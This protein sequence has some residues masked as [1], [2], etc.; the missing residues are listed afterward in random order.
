MTN[1]KNF[2]KLWQA[3]LVF[4]KRDL[5][6]RYA[7]SVLGPAWIVLYPLALI[8][9]TT[10]VFSFVF[11]QELELK[12][13][14]LHVMIGFIHWLFFSQSILK[15][16][17]AFPG[18]SGLI[19][20]HQFPLLALPISALF[21]RAVDYL[22]GLLMLIVA[23]LVFNYSFSVSLLL[24]FS[25]VLLVQMALQF[26]LGLFFATLNILIRDIQHLVE[27][28]LQIWF[29]ATPV[30]YTLAML[31]AS[32]GNLLQI[33]PLTTIFSSYRQLIFT[34][35]GSLPTDLWPVIILSLLVFSGGLWFFD[36]NK[37]QFA[38]LL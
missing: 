18:N 32:V 8:G 30:I 3:A 29:Y 33:N 1:F 5:K 26:G 19:K 37:H 7:S 23:M 24:S 22:V 36:R 38:E 2:P 10:F 25:L 9:I 28:L 27:I 34:S 35:S 31:P 14:A 6:V 13:Y 16:V 12:I 17:Y 21:S 20:N 11:S 4:L 15:I